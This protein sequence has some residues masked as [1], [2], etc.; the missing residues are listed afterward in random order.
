MIGAG[1]PRYRGSGVAIGFFDLCSAGEDKALPLLK[2]LMW[3]TYELTRRDGDERPVQGATEAWTVGSMLMSHGT[4]TALQ[5]KRAPQLIRSDGR[6]DILLQL[7]RRGSLCGEFNGA[8]GKASVGQILCSDLGRPSNVHSDDN[9][10]VMLTIPRDALEAVAGP[11]GKVHGCVLGGATGA[12][13]R[14][15]LLSLARLRGSGCDVEA[16]SSA[17]LGL[18][19]A[20]VGGE[21][22]H[23]GMRMPSAMARARELIDAQLSSRDLSADLICQTVGVSRSVLY[24]HFQG[25][26]GVER[27]ILERRLIFA[28]HCLARQPLGRIS[29]LAFNLGFQSASHFSTAYRLRFGVRPRDTLRRADQPDMSSAAARLA[30]WERVKS[31]ATQ[32]GRID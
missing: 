11:L 9:L 32:A 24:R 29:E 8:E 22:R 3:P 7:L 10:S 19:A 6:D 31:D 2:E 20:A 25:E 23:E 14:G 13:L 18:V 17:T 5:Y 28:R 30:R 27:Y 21:V 16:V 4:Q 26:G 12:L 15:H 1:R